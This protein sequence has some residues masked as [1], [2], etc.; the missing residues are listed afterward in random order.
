LNV[1]ACDK[2]TGNSNHMTIDKGH[3]SQEVEG[4]AGEAEMYKMVLCPLSDE[5]KFETERLRMERRIRELEVQLDE[6]RRGI[7]A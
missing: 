6:Y 2:T 7:P 3:L 5:S 4:V 1:S